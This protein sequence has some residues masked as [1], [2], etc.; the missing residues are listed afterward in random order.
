MNV[1]YGDVCKQDWGAEPNKYYLVI[2]L[3]ERIDNGTDKARQ[4]THTGEGA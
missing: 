1:I 3:G 2:K 4:E